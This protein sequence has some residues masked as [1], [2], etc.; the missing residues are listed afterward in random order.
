VTPVVLVHGLAV[1]HR[2]LMPLA[3]TLAGRYPVHVPDLPGFGPGR[4]K[5]RHALDVA[6]HAAF[7]AGWLADRELPPACLLG[8]SFGAEVV[9][10]TA[11]AFPDRVRALV[12]A[13]PTS[14]AAARTRRA[15]IGRWLR[16]VPR[17]AWWQGPILARD[18]RDAGV[19]RIFRTLGHSVRNRI[20]DDVARVHVPTVVIRGER[21][22]VVP[23]RWAARL[24]HTVTVAGAAH[25]VTTT[26]PRACADVVVALLEGRIPGSGGH[27]YRQHGD[28]APR[29]RPRL[30]SHDPVLGPGVGGA[31]DPRQPPT[32]TSPG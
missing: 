30:P 9:A 22:P 19:R 2:Y 29:R 3:R 26:A 21:D 17:E 15:Q 32:L 8:H 5:P 24:G 7:L 6:E 1:S 31:D 20:E 12:L 25:N 14:D 10:A 4:P 18:I 16:D 11:V 23:A 13:G 28:P 27:A